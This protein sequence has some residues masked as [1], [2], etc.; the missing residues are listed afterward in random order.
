M[1]ATIISG[2]DTLLTA[3]GEAIK[4]GHLRFTT[5]VLVFADPSIP[6]CIE[7][8]RRILN[9]VSPADALAV[10]TVTVTLKDSDS[11]L[12]LEPFQD[13][14]A[15][16][17]L[18]AL[19]SEYL[20]VHL[21]SLKAVVG[22]GAAVL[23]PEVIFIDAASGAPLST[24]AAEIIK[25]ATQGTRGGLDNLRNRGWRT[26]CYIAQDL[27]GY[28]GPLSEGEGPAHYS[29]RMNLEGLSSARLYAGDAVLVKPLGRVPFRFS[30]SFDVEPS[31]DCAAG[32]MSLCL[33]VNPPLHPSDTASV[34]EDSDEEEVD[35]AG[36][37]PPVRAQELPATA[38]EVMFT[39]GTLANLGVVPG[40]SV[41]I[42]LYPDPPAPAETVVLCLEGS[43][44]T[45]PESLAALHT[46]L[47]TDQIVAKAQARGVLAA[48]AAL[49]SGQTEDELL[50][51]LHGREGESDADSSHVSVAELRKAVN[52]AL[53]AQ[54]RYVPVVGG[55]I[56]H[57]PVVGESPLHPKRTV[58]FRVIRTSPRF[59]AVVVGPETRVVVME[60]PSKTGMS[61]VYTI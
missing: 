27:S 58:S 50:D 39:G 51:T 16:A 23:L 37:P 48:T 56:L 38:K 40:G 43:A 53:Q 32:G 12:L 52:E 24:D 29:A 60:S 59:V 57:A 30:S 17:C 25:R 61:T 55:Q 5:V 47:G 1:P 15:A 21:P 14:P 22:L 49:R 6:S 11:E 18:F 36:P 10:C 2:P 28:E 19:P 33:Y 20:R 3:A 45:A 44:V 35:G 7:V 13:H 4:I 8:L 46:L 9:D 41:S 26:N 54:C 31:V 42:E 34:S